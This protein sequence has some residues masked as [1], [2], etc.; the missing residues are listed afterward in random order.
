MSDFTITQEII[1]D[2]S[3]KI[4]FTKGRLSQYLD[5]YVDFY[6]DDY[7][8]IVNFFS[9]KLDKI[10]AGHLQVL[11]GLIDE[12][13]EIS[14]AIEE[15]GY[16]FSEMLDWEMTDYLEDLKVELFVVLKT[17]KFLRSSKTNFDFSG[18]IEIN[19]TQAQNQTLEQVA[20]DTL[21]SE[22]YDNDWVDI[23][24][25]NDLMESD[26]T[27]KGDTALVLSIPLSSTN[28]NITGVI[29]N[30]TGEKILGKDIKKKITYEDN[31]LLVLGYKDTVFQA[32][33]ILANLKKGHIPEFFD[34]GRSTFVGTS[35][36]ALGISAI[37]REM[38]ETFTSDDTL[39]NFSIR[40]LSLEGDSTFLEFYVS[41]RFDMIVNQNIQI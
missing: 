8:S 1:D 11:D 39:T 38:V 16:L 10:D 4:E 24:Q 31:D 34:L 7:P 23:A 5:S 19:K 17:S 26:Y 15:R 40:N 13:E 29:D 41:S 35:S 36:S 6:N 22:N 37:V 33:E 27:L 21:L 12:S 32:V 2:Y 14:Q 3:S 28:S 18:T 20:K 25:R 9:G 30:I